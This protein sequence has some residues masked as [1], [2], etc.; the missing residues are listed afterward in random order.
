[1]HLLSLLGTRELP[2]DE[3][4]AMIQRLHVPGFEE[5]RANFPRAIST[6]LIEPNLPKG[7]HWQTDISAVIEAVRSGDL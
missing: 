4:I 6:G 3:V 2:Q 5:A 7:F 1:V